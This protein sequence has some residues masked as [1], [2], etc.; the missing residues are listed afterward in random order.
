MGHTETTETTTG[1]VCR[2]CGG[3]LQLM[4]DDPLLPP[5]LRK[6]VHEDGSETCASGD[7]AAPIDPDLV[8]W[9]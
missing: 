6:A 1:R 2:G 5:P 7:L 3:A 4:G 8:S 9:P